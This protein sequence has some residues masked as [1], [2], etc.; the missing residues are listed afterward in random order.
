[1]QLQNVHARGLKQQGISQDFDALYLKQKGNRQEDFDAMDLEGDTRKDFDAM[2]DLERKEKQ[3]LDAR[4]ASQKDFDAT[5]VSK[6]EWA[7]SMKGGGQKDFEKLEFSAM[8]DVERWTSSKWKGFAA[9]G[10]LDGKGDTQKAFDPE[11]DSV[12][13]GPKHGLPTPSIL[14]KMRH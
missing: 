4:V 13:K 6:L 12:W 1:M 14:S 8:K 5:V 2:V 7:G 3:V 10:D 11:A 9:M